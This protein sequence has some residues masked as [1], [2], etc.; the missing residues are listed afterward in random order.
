MDRNFD[1]GG[2]FNRYEEFPLRNEIISSLINKSLTWD[3]KLNNL[4]DMDNYQYKTPTER[5][6]EWTSYK[7]SLIVSTQDDIPIRF[8]D[9]MLTGSI[10]VVH[11]ILKDQ[12]ESLEGIQ[13]IKNHICWFTEFDLIDFQVTIT[14]ATKIFEVEG[15]AGIKDRFNWAIKYHTRESV[16]KKIVDK[17]DFIIS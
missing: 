5:I 2:N 16:I 8:F 6:V 15:L 4:Y 1:L 17:L 9:A 14:R 13:P 10:P 7:S 3:I 12:I 11:V